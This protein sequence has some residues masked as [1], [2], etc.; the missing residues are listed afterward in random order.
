[1]KI[2][3]EFLD[4]YQISEEEAELFEMIFRRERRLKL[5]I[6]LLAVVI[7]AMGVVLLT[8]LR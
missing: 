6:A 4:L 2:D 1:M 3:K 5:V 7:L 8:R